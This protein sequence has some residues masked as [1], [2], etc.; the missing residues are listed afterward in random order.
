MNG[1]RNTFVLTEVT[2]FPNEL[3]PEIWE[4]KVTSSGEVGWYFFVVQEFGA[5]AESLKL[6]TM[7]ADDCPEL[8]KKG[9]PDSVLPELVRLHGKDLVSSNNFAIG[10]GELQSPD[11]VKVWERLVA[12]GIAKYCSSLERYVI[13]RESVR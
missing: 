4:Y 11:A 13:Y 6:V 12:S 10:S 1:E 8:R 2:G 3:E 7:R 9:I 5:D